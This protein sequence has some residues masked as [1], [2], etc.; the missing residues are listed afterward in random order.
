MFLLALSGCGSSAKTDSTEAHKVA[1]AERQFLNEWGK[2][3]AVVRLQCS[4][5][6]GKPGARCSQRILKSRQGRAMVKFSG[7]IDA[8]LDGGVGPKCAEELE[9]T[10]S[11]MTEVPYFPGDATAVCRAESKQQS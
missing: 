5:M 6:H 8:L 10:R 4:G 9:D 11:L 7:S 1:V 2:A 3:A